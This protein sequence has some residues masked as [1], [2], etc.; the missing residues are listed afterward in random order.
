VFNKH[1]AL[2]MFVQQSTTNLQMLTITLYVRH[3][4]PILCCINCL[5]VCNFCGRNIQKTQ[6]NPL[7]SLQFL[8]QLCKSPPTH[9]GSLSELSCIIFLHNVQFLQKNCWLFFLFGIFLLICGQ[10]SDV[11]IV[12]VYFVSVYFIV[13]VASLVVSSVQ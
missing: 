8:V 9:K 4:K 5:T 11:R 2:F 13:H 7:C 6:N 1:C 10:F 3:Q 12:F